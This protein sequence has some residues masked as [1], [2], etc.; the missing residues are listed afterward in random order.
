MN[1]NDLDKIIDWYPHLYNQVFLIVR[2]HVLTEEVLQETFIRAD[3]YIGDVEQLKKISWLRI[4]AKRLAFDTLKKENQQRDIKII[5]RSQFRNPYQQSTVEREAEFNLIKE[6]II[7]AI[8]ELNKH[9][10]E[11]LT[12][13]YIEG[14]KECEIAAKLNLNIGTV[15]SRIY[16]GRRLL[17]EKIQQLI[18]EY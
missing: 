4:T 10:H 9:Y 11:I 14:L 3:K 6:G 7:L 17:I 16:R 15:K 18:K 2:S 13:R 8:K 12:L 1:E 5:N